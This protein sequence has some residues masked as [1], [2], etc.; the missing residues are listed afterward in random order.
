MYAILDH[1]FIYGYDYVYVLLA[2]NTCAIVI[3]TF[4]FVRNRNHLLLTLLT[5]EGLILT[6]FSLMALVGA[7]FYD[8]NIFIL[9]FLTFV[10]C[11][12]ALG[13][14]LLV[15]VIRTHGRDHVNSLN[16]L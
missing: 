5:L 4:R 11:E 1:I 15:T 6:V 9:F 7:N 2:G 3:F 14:S 16:S 10:A 8:L 12:G 13:L